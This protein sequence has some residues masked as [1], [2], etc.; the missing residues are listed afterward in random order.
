MSSSQSLHADD[1][2]NIADDNPIEHSQ[3]QE[4]F[5]Y[6]PIDHVSHFTGIGVSLLYLVAAGATL[7]EV[8]ARYVFNAPTQWAFE[9]VMVLCAATWM[10]SAGYI[11]LKKRHIGI[12]VIHNIASP[13]N[14]WRLD[15]FAMIV[16]ITALFL[17]LADASL[18]AYLA[19]EHIERT[20]SAFNSPM[21]MIMKSLLVIGGLL[22][23]SQLTINL[24]RHVQS[25]WAKT[26]VKLVGLFMALYFINGL[27]AFV[28]GPESIFAS[29][30]G[31]FSAI[32]SSLDPSQA[33]N[34][35]SYSLGVI[36]LIM[37][38]MLVSLMMTGMPLGIVTLI[39]SVIM[40]IA[41]F[42]PRGLYLVS[43]N[44][45]ALLDHYTLIAIPFFVLMASILE[46]SGIAEDLF[47]AM[48]VFAG[49][50]RGGVAVQ[51]VVVA[52]ILAAM[53]GVMGGEI[54]MLGLVALPQ[55]LRLGYDRKM[56]IGLICAAG[57]LATLIPPSIIM[58]VYGLS[59][60][61]AIGDLF[62]A[63]A[64]PGL[65]L[66]VFYAVYVL[67]RVHINPS[68]APTAKEVAEKTGT[69]KKLS[70]ARLSAVFLSIMLIGCVMGSIYGG[71]ASVTEAAAVGALGAMGVSAV[72]HEFKW[73]MLKAALVGSMAT[74]GP[75][76]WLVLGSVS[77][78][79][80][81]NLIGGADFM[82][83][84]FMNLGIPA[85]GVILV[86]ML[87]LVVLGTFMEWIAIVLI[88]VPVF[89][90]VVM[91]LA[92]ELGLTEDQAKIW[93]GILFV[94]NI[95]IYFLSPPFGPACFWLKS[96]A[97]KDISLQEIFLSVLPFI[98]LQI[99][100]LILV[101]S[102]PQIALWLPEALGS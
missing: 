78:V 76:I 27:L 22:Y 64:V 97:P 4:Q 35:R 40:A 18:R 25:N 85:I 67:V 80:I 100:G 21:P 8:V 24:V 53:S 16:G 72:R 75:I 41:F 36:S 79:G 46:K 48:S 63:G 74:V 42:G 11:T 66:A 51:T 32:G 94:L 101:M 50:L 91:S 90:P 65:M 2:V 99:V 89:A 82:R 7:W 43:A 68:M 9:V 38:M 57:A 83:S 12:T 81:F 10:L 84:L 60:E 61:V 69:E 55:M 102:F 3:P 45:A 33:L 95:Q 62:M 73:S 26:I 13:K 87:I 30:S 23:L 39:V 49:N 47:D 52:V 59:A 71:I 77:F 56:T 19:I 92:P 14:Q 29:V 58:I 15:L 31:Y 98:G 34:M 1:V 5:D 28:S 37:V 93:F 54:V 70:R 96:V 44:T 17:L 6:T 88:T 86:M 20:G